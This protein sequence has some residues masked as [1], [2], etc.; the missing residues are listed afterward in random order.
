MLYLERKNAVLVRIGSECVSVVIRSLQNNLEQEGFNLTVEQMVLFK[1]L[2]NWWA[3]LKFGSG[4]FKRVSVR[5][6]N[7]SELSP[8]RQSDCILGSSQHRPGYS[9]KRAHPGFPLTED[10]SLDSHKLILISDPTM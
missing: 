2:H 4:W 8:E 6:L 9:Q 3:F 7:S 10:E 1:L 5:Y